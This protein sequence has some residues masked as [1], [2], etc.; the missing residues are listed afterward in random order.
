MK[1]LK[2][3][4]VLLF[5]FGGFTQTQAQFR[6]VLN[7]VTSGARAVKSSNSTTVRNGGTTGSVTE[8]DGVISITGNGHKRSFK[9]NGEKVEI[10]GNGHNITLKGHASEIVVLGTT[11]LVTAES[12]SRIEISGVDNKVY[13]TTSPNKNGRASSSVSGVDSRVIKQK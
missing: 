12:V 1:N 7:A 5:A 4:V 9:V 6:D 2:M 3:A 13:Y 11:N 8:Q 10:S